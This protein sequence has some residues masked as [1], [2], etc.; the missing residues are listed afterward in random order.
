MPASPKDGVPVP[1]APFHQRPVPARLQSLLERARAALEDAPH[2]DV[3]RERLV[4]RKV[5]GL[6]LEGELRGVAAAVGGGLGLFQDPV[7]TC[8]ALL[9]GAGE[10]AK[11]AA[12]LL[13]AGLPTEAVQDAQDAGELDL[14]GRSLD[15][16]HRP[17]ERAATAQAAFSRY[18]TALAL[19]HYRLARQALEH[20]AQARP[21]NPAYPD[22]LR[23]LLHRRPRLG[24]LRLVCG[25]DTWT[26]APS[27]AWVGR[28]ADCQV[29]WLAPGMSRRHIQAFVNAEGARLETGQGHVLW[30]APGGAQA[31]QAI[32][33]GSLS[34]EVG[35]SAGALL[36]HGGTHHACI[37]A[38]DGNPPAQEGLRVDVRN[39]DGFPV[40]NAA[41]LVLN[42]AV[43][44]RGSAELRL[45][46]TLHWRGQT[47]RVEDP[48]G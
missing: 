19:G 24:L 13:D 42:D 48:A 45:Q 6:T 8:A 34:V 1:W 37:L 46:D 17:Q 14:L 2:A 25:A 35:W 32:R 22:L 7:R 31:P 47:W 10:P 30:S 11:A 21:D 40:V 36:L 33:M 20:A 4:E 43:V 18:E 23:A 39:P 12:L 5:V 15:Q 28:G 29:R 38:A 27:P 44:A 9:R 3:Q 41:H 26:F 16:V